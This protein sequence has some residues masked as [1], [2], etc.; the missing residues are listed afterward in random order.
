MQIFNYVY[1]GCVKDVPKVK[2]ELL[3]KDIHA[4]SE[5]LGEMWLLVCKLNFLPHPTLKVLV[6]SG[7]EHASDLFYR[8]E[9]LEK[10]YRKISYN[11]QM[12]VAEL[13]NELKSFAEQYETVNRTLDDADLLFT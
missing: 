5:R 6:R 7:G 12:S 9:E 3:A 13:A 4:D 2:H 1:R 8:Q 11:K 10:E